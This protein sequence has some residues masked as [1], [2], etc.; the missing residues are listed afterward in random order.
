MFKK[1]INSYFFQNVRDQS[2]DLFEFFAV[3][4]K[5]ENEFSFV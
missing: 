1:S 3:V 5:K 2:L 4:Y